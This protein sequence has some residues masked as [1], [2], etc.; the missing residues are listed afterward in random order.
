M[1]H[2]AGTPQSPGANNRGAW[3]FA[4]VNS[5]PPTAP[6]PEQSY[7]PATQP[8]PTRRSVAQ[9]TQPPTPPQSWNPTSS[10]SGPVSSPTRRSMSESGVPPVPP[11]SS[12]GEEEP[13]RRRPP[14]WLWIVIGVVALGAIAA[15]VFFLM[16]PAA[17]E[18]LE[19]EIIT[20]PEPTPTIDPVERA[21]GT[22]FFESLPSEVLEFALA[23]YGEWDEPLLNGGLEGYYLVY[24]DGARNITLYAGQWRD[25]EGAE[26]AFD[27]AIAAAQAA[28]GEAEE[29]EASEEA[30]ADE[31]AAPAPSPE[32]GI[33]EVD[34]QQ[35][36]RW[37]LIPRAD[38][39]GS[40]WWTNQTVLLQLDGPLEELRDVFTAFP[41]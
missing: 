19:P 22:P 3:P 34:G 5:E 2:S 31:T 18:P 8:P 23:D 21:A 30:T 6:T 10:P 20:L 27:Q 1:S 24:S 35:V 13:G 11:D 32:D 14:L 25:A 28:P 17:P 38:G 16:R 9:V 7:P 29:P 26:A 36:G 41:L 4:P 39:T 15:V 12:E 33:V 40:L 37:M